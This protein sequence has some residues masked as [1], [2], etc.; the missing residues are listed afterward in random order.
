MIKNVTVTNHLGESLTM[1]LTQPDRSGFTV[2]SIDGLGPVKATVNMTEG[3]SVDGTSYNSARA[4]GRNIVIKLGF[5]MDPSIEHARLKSYRYF[6]I[7]KR[8]TL[9]I[10]TD[11]RTL[12]TFGWVESNQPDIF[13]PDSTG[14][15]SI[16]CTDSYF[17]SPGEDGLSTTAFYSIEPRFEFPFG[18]ESLA[19]KLLEMS[20]VENGVERQIF[21]EGDAEVGINIV[22]RATGPA[23]NVTIHNVGT[24]ESMTINTAKLAVITGSAIIAQDEIF[25]STIKGSKSIWLLRAGVYTNI[26][27]TLETN[28]DWFTLTKGVNVFAYEAATGVSN[29]QFTITNRVL[30]EGV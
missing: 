5:M 28:V 8:V 13:S 12:E 15:I 9:T 11:T 10:E 23:T 30:Y 27:N 6:P 7:K 25:I 18:N 3:G 24:R 21:Y 22:L 4:G 29:L 14:V 2:R 20:S 26:L 19:T 17:Y 1:E 16:V